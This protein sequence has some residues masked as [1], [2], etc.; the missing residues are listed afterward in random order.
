M[1]NVLTGRGGLELMAWQFTPYALPV[2]AAALLCGGLT[3][4]A[5]RQPQTPSARLLAGLTV[6]SAWWA[7][8]YALELLSVNLPAK[9]FWLKWQALGACLAPL[10]GLLF[11]I[12]FS[13]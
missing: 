8:S 3:L 6:A 7:L 4:Y 13:G 2:L 1:I 11:I 12:H 10:S 9:L 5:W